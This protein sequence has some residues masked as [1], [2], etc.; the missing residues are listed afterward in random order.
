MDA[1]SNCSLA[2]ERYFEAVLM[3]RF[4]PHSIT[5]VPQPGPKCRPT[6]ARRVWLCTLWTLETRIVTPNGVR[7][8][9]NG[10]FAKRGIEGAGTMTVTAIRRPGRAQAIEQLRLDP[11]LAKA[12]LSSLAKRWG[13]SRS[14]ARDWMKGDL[15]SDVLMPESPVATAMALAPPA[16]VRIEGRLANLPAY[17]AAGALA[18]VA[19]YFSVSGTAEIFPGAPVAGCPSGT[20]EATSWSPLVGLPATGDRP[21]GSCGRC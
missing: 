10:R 14:T 13:V 5:C 18:S 21:A 19:A 17:A 16:T 4:S 20:M 11:S 9:F 6:G 1:L 12:S 7:D 15:P 2:P 8:K 3:E